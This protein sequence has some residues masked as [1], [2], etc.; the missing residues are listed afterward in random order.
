M[1]RYSFDTDSVISE[2]N[3]LNRKICDASVVISKHKDIDVS[4]SSRD[5]VLSNNIFK[6]YRYQPTTH[7]KAST[8]ILINYALVNRPYILDLQDDRSF[9]KNLLDNGFDIYLIDWGYPQKKDKYLSLDD[10]ING[11]TH[12]SVKYIQRESGLEKINLMGICQGGALNL[13]YTSIHPGNISNLICINTPVDFRTSGDRLSHYAKHIK[14]EQLALSHGLIP[15]TMLNLNLICT[16]PIDFVTR[17]YANFSQNIDDKKRNELFLRIEK[18]SFDC[19]DQPSTVFNQF[20]TD[21]YQ[22]N[23]LLSASI[24]IGEHNI[25]LKKITTPILN[26]FSEKD[27]IVPPESSMALKG[28]TMT[29][30]YHEIVCQG[31]HISPFVSKK[32]LTNIPNKIAE[33][34][35]LRDNF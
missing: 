5:E 13:C 35:M 1:D 33:W 31:G 29:Q 14:F 16:N 3:E 30:D 24:K 10:Y 15:G 34:L 7:K 28:A 17:K 8:P 25:D 32:S 2:L 21:F 23:K 9:I 20:C 4:P 27:K 19:P 26:I 6:L 11:F 12:A 18:W 22:Q